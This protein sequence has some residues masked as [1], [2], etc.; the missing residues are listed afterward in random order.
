M[1]TTSNI[2]MNLDKVTCW[3]CYANTKRLNHDCK[4][5][6]S[7]IFPEDKVVSLA[8]YKKT[9]SNFRKIS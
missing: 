3:I 9:H 8:E 1:E 4:H 7:E 5:I 6:R 2:S